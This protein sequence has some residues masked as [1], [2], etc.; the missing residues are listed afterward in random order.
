LPCGRTVAFDSPAADVD[1]IE[2]DG[3]YMVLRDGEVQHRLR[4][5]LTGLTVE[6][7]PKQFASIAP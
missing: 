6:L 5:S 4:A 1:W 2:A 7:D 3:N